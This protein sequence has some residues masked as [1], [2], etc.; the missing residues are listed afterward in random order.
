MRSREKRLEI[1][2]LY[3]FRAL[4][5][6]FVANYHI[7]QQSW[8]WQSVTLGG[9]KIDFDFFTRSSYLFVDGMILLSGFLLFLPYARQ[10]QEGTLAPGP[11]RF[12]LNRLKRIVP[13]YLAAV[14]LTLTCIALPQ[15]LFLD[16]RAMVKD[17]AAHLTFTQVFWP[18]TY[19]HTP[20]NVALWTIA[21]E[22]QYY[23]LF[24]W[25]AR[26]AQKRPAPV[27]AGMA[28]LSWGYRA[29]VY[30]FATAPAMLINQLPAFLD[31]YALG[32]LGAMAYCGARRGLS[33]LGKKGRMSVAWICAAVFACGVWLVLEILRIQSGVSLQGY[34]AMQRNQ[35]ALRLP[36]AL[37]LLATML[38]AAFM[39][40]LLQK[41]L[42]NRLTRFFSTIS[43]NL[44]I[45]HQVLAVEMRKAW[46]GDAE[47]LHAS[48]SQQQ[49]YTALSFSVAVL[50]A[51][52][53][54]YGLEKPAALG[55]EKL[56]DRKRRQRQTG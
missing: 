34:D 26:W 54:T 22:M 31:V 47:A 48:L 18:E 32:M 3:G 16:R 9:E 29:G 56:A 13:S 49:A 35:L 4:M 1:G 8:L 43:M 15:N 11:G 42:N 41:L 33:R 28:L 39:P 20:L 51:M 12:Y 50:A 27:L 36:L 10:R 24:P 7:W 17:V 2:V 23:A 25:L 30:R 52:A 46:F 55:L 40:R 45:W 6:L 53:F 38:S 21:V 37:C 14:L 19:I 5:V 44:Y